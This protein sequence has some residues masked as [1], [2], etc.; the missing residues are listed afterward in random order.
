MTSA[1]RIETPSFDAA[2]GVARFPYALGD[3]RFT[4]TLQ[5]PAGGADAAESSAFNKLLHLT[6]VVLGVSYFKLLA[7]LRIIAEF[8]LTAAERDFALDVYSNGL[9][10]FYARN[11]LNH[12]GR[13]EIEA[14]AGPHQVTAVAAAQGPRAAPDRRRQ[15][16]AGLGG[17]AR[18]RRPRLFALRR[19]SQG[20]DPHLRRQV[21]LE[22]RSM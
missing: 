4:E 18:S 13:I 22:P 1:F 2:T 3:V 11:N 5:F 9:G 14:P 19:Q 6:A 17:A 21:R 7:P 10:E 20:S 16:L 15:G 12:F 8:P